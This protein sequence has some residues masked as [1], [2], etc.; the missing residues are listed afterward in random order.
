MQIQSAAVTLNNEKQQNTPAK[1][2][3]VEQLAA[4]LLPEL[5]R[6]PDSVKGLIELSE[7]FGDKGK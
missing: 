5:I 6:N 7:R 2:Q 4:E 3:F 1:N